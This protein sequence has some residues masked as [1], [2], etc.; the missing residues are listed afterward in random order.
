MNR[1][2]SVELHNGKLASVLRDARDIIYFDYQGQTINS[3]YDMVLLERL[4]DEIKK[5]NVSIWRK[6][7]LF[8]QDN[9]LCHKSIKTTAKL[10]KLGYELL[11]H[12]PYS[13]DLAPSDFFLF[14]DLKR[15]LAGQKFSINQEVNIETE[16]FFEA[17]SKSYHKNGIENLYRCVAL[18]RNYIE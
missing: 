6:R 15:M 12:P 7:M 18:E 8:H 1:I 10:H 5:Q 3:E 9:A 4:N 11:L 14:A 16:T 17:M 13:P 2:Q